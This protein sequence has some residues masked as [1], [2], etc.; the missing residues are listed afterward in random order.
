MAL[1]QLPPPGPAWAGSLMGTAIF[2]SLC[3]THGLEVVAWAALFFSLGVLVVLVTGWLRYRVPGWDSGAMAP[4]GMVAMGVMSLGSASTAIVGDPV[5]QHAGWWIGAPLAWAVCVTQLRQFPGEP[6]FQWG[7]ALVAPMV[8]ATTAGQLDGRFYHAAGV[9][10]FF[11]TLCTAIPVFAYCYNEGFHGRL[12]VPDRLGGTTWIPL[13]VGPVLFA[14]QRFA[15][16]VLRWAE[17]GPGWWGATFPVGALSL[18]AHVLSTSTGWVWLD[19]V[20][21]ALLGLT[22]LHIVLCVARFSQW[23]AQDRPRT[24]VA[25]P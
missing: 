21:Q 3:H 13:G 19:V 9:A 6:T 25:P 1:Q 7:L 2:A 22:A 18:G 23:V 10:S 15:R 11:L 5:W 17:Y 20:S 16:S 24:V 8:A 14:G 12:N 4:W